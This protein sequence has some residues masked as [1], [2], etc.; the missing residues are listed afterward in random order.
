MT[1]LGRRPVPREAELCLFIVVSFQSTY[2]VREFRVPKPPTRQRRI[3]ASGRGV[4]RR[5]A[6][7]QD[8][9]DFD[10]TVVPQERNL[11]QLSHSDQGG[12]KQ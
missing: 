9:D 3:N 5:R 2:G 8:D 7:I 4:V 10:L 11:L 12:S 6:H 1:T